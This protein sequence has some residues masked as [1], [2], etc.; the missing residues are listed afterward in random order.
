VTEKEQRELRR[1]W[2]PWAQAAKG[3]ARPFI[4]IHPKD[5]IA[6][7][8]EVDRLRDLLRECDSVARSGESDIRGLP[9]EKID[10]ALR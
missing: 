7:L 1:R 8:D 6:L 5:V 4:P 3:K 2:E 10:A 9:W